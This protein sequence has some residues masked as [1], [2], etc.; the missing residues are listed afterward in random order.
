MAAAN[1]ITGTATSYELTNGL[2]LDISE[3][4]TLTDPTDTPFLTGEGMYG[5]KILPVGDP[6]TEIQFSWLE[7]GLMLPRAAST[8]TIASGV[9]TLVVGAAY[10]KNFNVGHVLMNM[11]TKELVRVTAY[12]STDSLTITRGF[13]GTTAAAITTGD[14]L[15]SLGAVLAEGSAPG[16]GR[17]SDRV[18]PYNYSQIFGP[19]QV[20]LSKTEQLVAKY[21]VS[22]EFS[23][24]VMNLVTTMSISQEQAILYGVRY[25]DTTNKYR[26][27]GGIDW[28]INQ[29]GGI[30]DSSSTTLTVANL[31]TNLGNCF[32]AGG[33]PDLLVANPRSLSDL[34]D[35][36]NTS[37]VRIAPES[38]FRGR[39]PV[40]VC[41]TE[42]GD[43]MIVRNRWVSPK[44]A[45]GIIDGR[46]RRRILRSL[47]MEALAKT[48]DSDNMQVVGEESL[49]VRGAAHFFRYT[50]LSYT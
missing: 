12:V 20:T 28:W 17:A 5:G 16:N 46:I 10:Q 27:F 14:T 49:E 36:T 50:G 31:Q 9:T 45:F 41:S 40:Q 6:L 38:G 3:M 19:E 1:P 2:R 23:H 37:I 35:V 24:Q 8:T 15:V 18:L 33:I 26:T 47:G 25:N 7:E 21:G 13:G 22:D 11:A 29:Q 43:I 34:T 44:H 30:T 4:I 42:F 32:N 39:R 48:G